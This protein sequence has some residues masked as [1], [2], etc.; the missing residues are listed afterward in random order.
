MRHPRLLPCC[1]LAVLLAASVPA[2]AAYTLSRAQ[3]VPGALA[4]ATAPPYRLAAGVAQPTAGQMAGGDYGLWAG[5]LW[6][7]ATSTAGAD[8]GDAAV[9]RVAWRAPRPNPALS[10]TTLTFELPAA[11]DVRVSVFAVDGRR[12][13]TLLA[14][15]REPGRYS[16]AWACTDA[17]GRRVAPGVYLAVLEAGPHPLSQRVVVLDR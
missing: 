4:G 5:F 17:G 3:V 1:C 15:R 2:H 11:S 9:T 12:V 16:I 13:T 7:R 6:P 8:R 14:G 10:G